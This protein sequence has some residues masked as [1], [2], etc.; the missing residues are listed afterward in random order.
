MDMEFEEKNRER[1]ADKFVTIPQGGN[2]VEKTSTD[3]MLFED[4]KNIEYKLLQARK[5]EA[6]GTLAGGIAHDFN[7]LLMGIQGNAS[8]MLLNI[9]SSHPHYEKLKRIE[10]QVKNGAELTRQLLGFARGGKYDVR[11][12]GLNDLVKKTVTRFGHDKEEIKILGRYQKDIW[13][14][15]VDQGQIEQ[16]LLSLYDNAWQAMPGGGALYLETE[17]V[18]LEKDY[19]KLFDMKPGNYVK[20]SVTDTGI[21]MDEATRQKIFEP[22]FTTKKMGRGKGLGL[23]SVYGIIK[24][25][26]GLIHVYS[27]KGH[28][29]T[30]NIYLPAS[31][32]LTT[33]EDALTDEVIRGDQTIL[34]VDDEKMILD[35]GVEILESLG[36]KVISA[37]GGREAIDII[38]HAH[39]GKS[40]EQKGKV[41]PINSMP[42][43]VI[44]DLMM[45]DMSGGETYDKIKGIDPKIKVLLSSGY[46]V[47]GRATEILKRGCNGFIQKPFSIKAI[48]QKIKE[49]LDEK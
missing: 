41:R 33:G 12:T 25:H 46:S 45:P 32:N 37:K 24:N 44:L 38:R 15:E 35:V 27:E 13:T 8:L 20:F 30:F 1:F 39:Q 4:K 11:P 19:C 7:N 29:T 9:D 31:E 21:G 42:D 14:V 43:L 5:M 3:Q 10:E 22:F 2:N 28:G 34:I 23:A 6:L 48:S 18:V 36:Y 26:G 40:K 17:N 49:I 16:V 47:N